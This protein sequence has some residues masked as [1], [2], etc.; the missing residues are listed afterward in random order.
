MENYN[1]FEQVQIVIK[2]KNIG[3]NR[4]FSIKEKGGCKCVNTLSYIRI[5]EQRTSHNGYIFILF[6]FAVLNISQVSY[7]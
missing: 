2:F 3:T 4:L 6:S 5:M 1:V 7:T